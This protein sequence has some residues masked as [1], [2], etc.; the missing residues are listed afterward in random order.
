MAVGA[1]PRHVRARGICPAVVDALVGE[2]R[3]RFGIPALQAV[4]R[5]ARSHVP[6][7]DLA[8]LQRMT[9]LTK[10][11]VLLALFELATLDAIARAVVGEL[12]SGLPVAHELPRSRVFHGLARELHDFRRLRLRRRSAAD[13]AANLLRPVLLEALQQ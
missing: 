5:Q 10:P 13:L 6:H 11:A 3:Y 7:V 1:Q 12:G 4:T 9:V 2:P 8:P